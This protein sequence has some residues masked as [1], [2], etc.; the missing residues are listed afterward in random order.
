[1]TVSLSLDETLDERCRWLPAGAAPLPLDRLAAQGWNA[2]AGDLLLPV[3]V[4]KERALRHN[5]DLMARYCQESGVSLAPHGK[6]TM[7][8]QLVRLQLAAGAWAVTAANPAQAR[9]FQASGARRVV[10][11]NQVVEPA[12]LRWIASALA[13]DPDLRLLC[14]V[15]APAGVALMDEALQAAG[16]A[17][18][19]DVLIELGYPGGRAGCRT[20]EEAHE[21]AAAVLGSRHLRLAGVETFEGL[22]SLPDETESLAAV[23]GLLD[24]LR[25]F[26]GQLDASGAFADVDEIV[27]TAGGS[28]YFDRVVARLT[29]GW[30]LSRQVHVVLRSGCYLTHDHGGYEQHGPMGSRLDR[31]EPLQ[32]AME[33]WGAVHSR[34]EPGLAILGFGKRDASYDMGLPTALRVRGRD[35]AVREA[36]GMEITGLNDQ[37]ARLRVPDSDPLGPGDLVGCGLS[38]PCTVFDKWRYMPLVDDEY[39]VTGAISTWF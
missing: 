26:A 23:D 3:L 32:Q 27:V 36:A 4:L 12:G 13:D 35:G 17:R 10:I 1:M 18:R 34:P 39:Q 38:H 22:I 7:S 37:H 21:V 16:S 30:E 29:G 8:P 6:T 19:L 14:L 2:L 15:D 31:W 11:A 24:R 20:L 9:I 5:L 28:R 33:I 25:Q